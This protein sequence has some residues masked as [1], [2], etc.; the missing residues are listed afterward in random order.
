MPV[1]CSFICSSS[2]YHRC[3]T[4]LWTNELKSYGEAIGHASWHRNRWQAGYVYWDG[5]NV[6]HIHLKRIIDF[7][8]YFKSNIWRCRRNQGIKLKE[9]VG[10]LTSYKSTNLLSF[11]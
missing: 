3:V 10:E 7:A 8:P 9:R 4:K 2:P 11:L 1:G 6:I 5:A